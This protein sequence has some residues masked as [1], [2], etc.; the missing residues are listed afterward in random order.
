M[1]SV[2][3]PLVPRTSISVGGCKTRQRDCCSR[4]GTTMSSSRLLTAA[5]RRNHQS[6]LRCHGNG[7]EVCSGPS[8]PP[9]ADSGG[10]GDRLCGR[11]IVRAGAAVAAVCRQKDRS[12]CP[13]QSRKQSSQTG[14]Y[15]ARYPGNVAGDQRR[16]A[17]SS[18]T[19]M[20]PT[21]IHRA[22]PHDA[23]VKSFTVRANSTT[24]AAGSRA[25]LVAGEVP[26]WC[27]K[28][29]GRSRLFGAPVRALRVGRYLTSTGR[30]MGCPDGGPTP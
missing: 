18:S 15:P 12:C 3:R 21:Q 23:Y 2:L 7:P 11:A 9:D 19:D 24:V 22:A 13:A 26:S 28:R 30:R 27:A 4:S 14:A 1:L 20:I 5:W 6:R 29:P 10:V 17:A 8:L 16:P 25:A